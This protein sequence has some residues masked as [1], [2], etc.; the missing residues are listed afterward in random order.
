MLH[1]TFYTEQTFGDIFRKYNC[2]KY[3]GY[4]VID[5]C[6][7]SKS[8]FKKVLYFH[9]E[10]VESLLSDQYENSKSRRIAM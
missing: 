5:Y 10:D 6:M 8:L 4:S 7:V 1:L 9:V 3:N 2:F